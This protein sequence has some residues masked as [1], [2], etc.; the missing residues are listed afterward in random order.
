L[1]VAVSPAVGQSG[2]YCP[3]HGYVFDL[4][5]PPF[6]IDAS[7]GSGL[8]IDDSMIGTLTVADSGPAEF[9][10]A[11]TLTVN[12]GFGEL[13]VD[14]DASLVVVSG[15]TLTLETPVEQEDIINTGALTIEIGAPG[16]LPM[17]Y[18]WGGEI[19]LTDSA[20]VSL[21]DNWAAGTIWLETS[22][23]GVDS[24]IALPEPAT[25]AILAMAGPISLT[26]RRRQT[27]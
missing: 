7:V 15:G 22:A 23:A 9:L 5:A 13:T 10:T 2:H 3:E 24:I 11:G 8:I 26:R 25:L 12:P 21:G 17:D 16:L 14:P 19:T 20:P 6:E 27:R 4:W 18:D 1:L